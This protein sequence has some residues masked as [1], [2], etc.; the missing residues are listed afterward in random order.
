MNKQVS[1]TYELSVGD[2][3]FGEEKKNKEKNL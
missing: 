3:C 1:K 2:K